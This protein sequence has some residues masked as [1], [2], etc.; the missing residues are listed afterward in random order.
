[1][2]K[3]KPSTRSSMSRRT[4]VPR[5]STSTKSR[6]KFGGPGSNSDEQ[7]LASVRREQSILPRS[8]VKSIAAFHADSF[9]TW[10]EEYWGANPQKLSRFEYRRG[11][12]MAILEALELVQFGPTAKMEL[13]RA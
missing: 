8:T 11:F 4:S 10:Q 12:E 3:S 13:T 1:M 2:P 9:H 5:C 6:M 7:S